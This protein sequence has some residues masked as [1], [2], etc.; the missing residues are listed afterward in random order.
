[1]IDLRSDTVTLPTEEMREAMRRAELGDD[2]REGDPTV[3][4]LEEAAAATPARRP[5]CSS[6]AAPCRTWWRCS[7]IPAAAARCCS[8]PNRTSCAARWAASPRSPGCSTAP[9]RRRAA[10]PISARSREQLSERLSANRLATALVCV[11]TTHNSAGGARH[12]AG[13][14]GQ[15][16]AL[17]AEKGIPRAYRRRAHLQRR[18]GARRTGRRD[19]APWRQHRLL[20]Q[21]GLERAVRLGAVR[22]GGVH[23][24]RARLSPHG[25]RRHAPGRR[26]GGGGHRRAGA[27]DRPARR[28]SPPRE[29]PR[30]G[31]ARD[32]SAPVRSDAVDTNIVMFEVGH[33]GADAKTWIAA[34]EGGRPEVA[35]PGAASRCGSSRTATST[36]RRSSRRC[37]I[38]RSVYEK[39]QPRLSAAE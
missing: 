6:P 38:V 19:R 31:P 29:A 39:L 36:M 3:R 2:S 25:R 16:R 22:L 9:F 10:R 21:Q 14:S 15:L 8:T 32:R 34:L 30:R 33:T 24:T 23:R 28:G 37:A 5:R 13:L 1:M 27:H 18:G 12:S 7:P 17:T 4:R 35:A 26:H 11:E 20:R